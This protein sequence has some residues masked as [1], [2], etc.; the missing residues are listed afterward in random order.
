MTDR[1]PFRLRSALSILWILEW[2]I[3]GAVLTYMPL[4]FKQNGIELESTG[5]LFAVG[6]VGLWVAPF[7]VGQVCDR[8]MSTEK[9]LAIAHFIGGVTLMAIPVATEVYNT[10]H[11]HFGALVFLMGLYAACYLPT[12]PLASSLTFRHLPNPRA[13]FGGIRLW[14]TVG[15]V[16]AGLALSIWLGRHDFRIWFL[17]KFPQSIN[18]VTT[19]ESLL[20]WLPEPASGD[21]FK[22]AAYLSFALAAFCVFLPETPPLKTRRSGFA[23]LQVLALLKN[24]NFATLI[25][26]AAI[27]SLVIPLYTLYVPPLLEKRA[28]P[29]EWVPA[30]MTIGQISEF[31]AL[32]VLPYFLRYLGLKATFAIGMAAWALRYGLF[33]TASDSY[34]IYVGIGL[35]GICHVFLVIVIQLFVDACCPADLRASAQNLFL[36]VTMGIALPLGML[37]SN[38]LVRWCTDSNGFVDFS[39]LFLVPATLLLLLMAVYWRCI[40]LAATEK[41]AEH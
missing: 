36:F 31:P 41:P 13:Q 18:F 30:V 15:W 3:T 1:I 16:V 20:S 37:L 4:Y 39:R 7:V 29:A 26:I 11:R 10:T 24:P 12:M 9:Y 6:A 25:A 38:P 17:G 8:W 19:I 27:M 33:A 21:C 35:H 32:L 28:V 2:G 34:W 23:P 14:G 40:R 22:I 5:P